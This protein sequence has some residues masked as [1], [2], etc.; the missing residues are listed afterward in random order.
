MTNLLGLW[1][2][3]YQ[4]KKPDSRCTPHKTTDSEFRLLTSIRLAVMNRRWVRSPIPNGSS[5]S[6]ARHK[7][8]H[9][10]HNS[11]QKSTHACVHCLPPEIFRLLRS[12][13]T[14][15]DH[16]PSYE[17]KDVVIIQPQGSVALKVYIVSCSF[18]GNLATDGMCSICYKKHYRSAVEGGSGVA[19]TTFEP[20]VV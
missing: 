1:A 17:H 6:N 15:H 7:P 12:V 11:T 20:A 13:I 9:P 18:F 4:K 10:P 8:P 19:A 2:D 16:V 3:P 14:I 5:S